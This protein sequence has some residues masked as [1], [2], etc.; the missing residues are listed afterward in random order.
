[1][2]GPLFLSS[3]DMLADRRYEF[4]KDLLA[5]GDV[6]AA[7]DLLAQTVELAPR[8]A[9]AW[10]ALGE[11]RERLGEADAAGEAFREAL[12]WDPE[13][14]HGA[15]LQVARLGHQD[16][17]AALSYVRTLF[18][19]YA[20]KF[21][22]AL[23]DGLGYRAPALLRQAVEAACASSGR[24]A[25]FASALDLGCGTGL[26]GTEFRPLVAHLTGVDLSAGMVAQAEKKQLYDRLD[27]SEIHRFL[28]REHAA[29]QA[30]DLVL[31][32]DVFIYLPDLVPVGT[33]VS[34]VLAPGGLFAFTVE[35]HAGA[36][37]E[38]GPKLRFAHGTEHVRA[39]VAGLRLLS[40]TPASTRNE[41]GAPV[42]GLI[43][44]AMRE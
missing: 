12:R 38:L 42:P 7:A 23:V 33:A 36:G 1:M 13:D 37:V 11:L 26:C 40:L 16:T 10:F 30:F 43:A 14:R 34:R 4:A 6:A 17:G 32:A 9:S 24:P 39:A 28:E 8:F 27:V 5:R 21:D 20:D 41:A 44:V 31:S 15:A 19:Q 2:R 29:G 35:T 22:A 25:Q 3:G 18:D